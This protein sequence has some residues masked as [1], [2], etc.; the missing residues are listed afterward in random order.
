MKDD[1]EF[2]KNTK[3]PDVRN[4]EFFPNL[5]LFSDLFLDVVDGREPKGLASGL[6]LDRL[7]HVPAD[8]RRI[9]DRGQPREELL[10]LLVPLESLALQESRL[11]SKAHV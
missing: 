2:V 11:T 9:L 7:V 1:L 10:H 5:I 6:V 3:T 8:H 4:S